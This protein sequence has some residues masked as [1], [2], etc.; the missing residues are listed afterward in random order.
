MKHYI[1]VNKK[2]QNEST[3]LVE[4]SVMNYSGCGDGVLKLALRDPNL[5]LFKPF[6]SLIVI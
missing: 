2:Y 6:Y 4:R 1:T 3:A 5:S